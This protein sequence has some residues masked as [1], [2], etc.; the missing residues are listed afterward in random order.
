MAFALSG[1]DGAAALCL[2]E[3]LFVHAQVALREAAEDHFLDRRKFC[4]RC[5]DRGNGD[6]ACR[7]D[8]VAIDAGADAGKGDRAQAVARCD[9]QRPAVARGQAFGLALCAATPHRSHRMDYESGGQAMALGQLGL[10]RRAAPQKPALG[11]QARAGG[12]MNGPVDAAPAKE[13]G[14]RGIDDGIDR[15]G[16]EVALEGAQGGGH[17]VGSVMPNR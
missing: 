4:E 10:A 8:R 5:L 12:P 2:A 17:G 13:R 14:V 1:G 6:L 7:F 16:G 11:Q 3:P 15:E 9:L